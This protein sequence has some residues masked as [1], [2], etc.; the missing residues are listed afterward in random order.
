MEILTFSSQREKEVHETF[1]NQKNTK[2]IMN[3]ILH[4]RIQPVT[5]RHDEGAGLTL[6]TTRHFLVA[7]IFG[8]RLAINLGFHQ[9]D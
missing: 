1:N 7:W 2:N 9:N 5:H 8:L 4:F 3:K 6:V